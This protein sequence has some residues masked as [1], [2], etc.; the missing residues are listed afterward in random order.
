MEKTRI[1]DGKN[2]DAGKTPWISTLCKNMA[3]V[4]SSQEDY[5]AGT[6]S[7]VLT[8]KRQARQ[9]NMRKGFPWPNCVGGGRRLKDIQKL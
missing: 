4:V 6:W 8:C 2:S 1:R 7:T 9:R 5:H 3:K